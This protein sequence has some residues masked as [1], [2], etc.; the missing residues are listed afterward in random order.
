MADISRSTEFM[1]SIKQHCFGI[2]DGNRTFFKMTSVWN[3][4]I[5]TTFRAAELCIPE[6]ASLANTMG[7]GFMVLGSA[8]HGTEVIRQELPD[9][10]MGSI[11]LKLVADEAL[12]VAQHDISR[13]ISSVVGAQL[14]LPRPRLKIVVGCGHVIQSLSFNRYIGDCINRLARLMV[15]AFPSDDPVDAIVVEDEL[16]QLLPGHVIEACHLRQLCQK[17]G[18]PVEQTT[19]GGTKPKKADLLNS[20]LVTVTAYAKLDQ[21]NITSWLDLRNKAAHWKYSEYTKEQVVNLI[22]GIREFMTRVPA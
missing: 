21:K 18:I 1:H 6:R 16:F 12:G 8:E 17:V 4:A 11:F 5:E 14:E 19:G 7:D 22:S 2:G 10:I 20:E 9:L 3:E 13:E 15:A